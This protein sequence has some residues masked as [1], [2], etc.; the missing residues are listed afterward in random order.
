MTATTQARSEQS[1]AGIVFEGDILIK[2]KDANGDWGQPIGPISPVKLSIN[3]GEIT[4]KTRK[5]RLRGLAGQVTDP[6]VT[7]FAEPKVSFETDDSNETL[8]NL[9]LRGSS[10]SIAE[11]GSSVTD[12]VTA[13]PA[14]GTWL[15]L[16]H[17]NIST[18][19]FSGKHANNSALTAGTDYVI[20]DIW[21]QHGLV[22]IPAGSGIAA[23][24]ACK[25]SYTYGAVSG[26]GVIGNQLDQ[27]TV[28]IEMFGKNRVNGQNVHITIHE[29]AITSG[30]DLDLGGAD[31]YFKPNF[32]GIMSTPSGESGP[33]EIEFLTFA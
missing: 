33:Y 10:A 26:T 6:V 27:V 12:D 1:L 8:F 9:I 25:W 29:I 13:V 16:P 32:S 3:P 2:I 24:E 11:S 30:V 22:Y 19:A 20:Q 17:R 23:A 18:T 14:L 15:Q 4:T 31:D 21:L 28:N 5:L 7:D